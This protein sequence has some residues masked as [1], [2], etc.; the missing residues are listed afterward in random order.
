MLI[1]VSIAVIRFR[2]PQTR[3]QVLLNQRNDISCTGAIDLLGTGESRQRDQGD[4]NKFTLLWFIFRFANVSIG[5]GTFSLTNVS[6][7]I[8]CSPCP[9]CKRY[10]G[11]ACNATRTHYC[12]A[13]TWVSILS[14]STQP[15]QRLFLAEG[16]R[17]TGH[18]VSFA[19]VRDFESPVSKGISFSQERESSQ[20]YE[21]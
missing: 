20:G 7:K 12:H 17:E 18:I 6:S 8:Q 15:M 19:W 1:S 16:L 9:A 14:P 11:C 10:Q 2:S 21:T 5:Q 4:C 13:T 3:F